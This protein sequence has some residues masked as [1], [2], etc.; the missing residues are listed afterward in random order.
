MKRL[1][2][3]T[4]LT[5]AQLSGSDIIG[6]RDQSAGQTKYITVADLTGLP[7][8]GWIATGESHAFSSFNSAT[9]IGVITVPSDATIKYTPGMKYKFSQTTGGTKFAFIVA[10]TTTTISLFFSNGITLNNEAITSPVYTTEHAPIGYTGPQ[11]NFEGNWSNGTYSERWVYSM[12]GWGAITGTGTINAS[13]AVS[14]G[15]TFASIPNVL[16]AANGDRADTTE[17]VGGGGNTVHGQ[18]TG[19]A[20]GLLTT[21]FTAYLWTISIG[22]TSGQRAYY[23]WMAKGPVT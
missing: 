5:A 14:Y 3:L 20:F 17:V 23:G 6:I 19:K 12:S 1:D 18:V 16:I 22:W 9:R 4:Q 13:E 10:V 15:L 7:T 11:L 8:L 21:G 2:Q